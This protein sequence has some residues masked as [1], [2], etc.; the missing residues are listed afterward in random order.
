MTQLGLD[1]LIKESQELS[2]ILVSSI[3]TA[4]K[5]KNDQ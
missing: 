4:S 1:S 2:R 5:M 3:K